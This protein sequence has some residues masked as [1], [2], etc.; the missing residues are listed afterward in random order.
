MI[1]RGGIQ[2]WRQNVR[3]RDCNSLRLNPQQI[4]TVDRDA[5][6]IESRKREALPTYEGECGYQPMLAVWAEM[7]VVLADEFR[8]G[9]V[10]AQMNPLPVAQRAFAALPGTVK[11][12]YYRGDS[13]CHEHRLINW[14]RDEEREGESVLP[15]ARA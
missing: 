12:F 13:A 6:I 9:N 7:N 15:S 8:D 10:P 2:T 3:C 5:T 14:L 1:A 11:T 4:A